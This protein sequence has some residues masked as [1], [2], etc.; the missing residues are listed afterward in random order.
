IVNV[1]PDSFSDGD[2][3][4]DADRAAADALRMVEQGAALLDIGGESTRPGARPADADE[5]CR[6][7]GPVLERLRGRAGVPISIDTYKAR[8]AE[9]ALAAG[10]T[11]VTDISGLQFDPDLAGVVARSG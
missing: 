1:T 9:R 11:I 10:A 3:R 7:V 6:R 4:F 5:E 2:A 8:T